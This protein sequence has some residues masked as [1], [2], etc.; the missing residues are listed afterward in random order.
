MNIK[1]SLSSTHILEFK[2]EPFIHFHFFSGNVKFNPTQNSIPFSFI[3][4]YMSLC[5]WKRRNDWI[6]NLFICCW[7]AFLCSSSETQSKYYL[8][9]E[10][11]PDSLLA[12]INPYLWYFYLFIYILIYTNVY[13]YIVVLIKLYLFCLHVYL[14]SQIVSFLKSRLIFSS[15]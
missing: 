6:L 9:Y 8:F 12:L 10:A 7:F 14:V 15:A 2:K 3:R 13:V 5:K 1:V 4:F 11:F